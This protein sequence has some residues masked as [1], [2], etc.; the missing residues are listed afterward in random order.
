VVAPKIS[1]PNS[2]ESLDRTESSIKFGSPYDM[3][4][5][6]PNLHVRFG[7]LAMCCCMVTYLARLLATVQIIS[8]CNNRKLFCASVPYNCRSFLV[9]NF[10]LAS[11]SKSLFRLPPSYSPLTSSS[12]DLTGITFVTI[13]F[14]GIET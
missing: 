9:P 8:A 2:L 13:V 1:T 10:S 4:P 11:S 6:S 7:A 3:I 5:S 14:C 12:R